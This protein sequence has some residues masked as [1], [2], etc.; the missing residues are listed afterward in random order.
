MWSRAGTPASPTGSLELLH[1][2]TLVFSRDAIHAVE[3]ASDLIFAK[4][5]SAGRRRSVRHWG[6]QAQ[7]VA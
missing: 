1:I 6:I 7:D 3:R 4:I 5:P 2:V